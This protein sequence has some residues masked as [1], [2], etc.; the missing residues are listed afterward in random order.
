MVPFRAES[1]VSNHDNNARATEMKNLFRL[2][3]IFF[4]GCSTNLNTA[5]PAEVVIFFGG[6]G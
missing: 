3:H 2:S 5:K 4:G 6:G 1:S